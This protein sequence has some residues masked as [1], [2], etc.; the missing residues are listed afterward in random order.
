MCV[1]CCAAETDTAKGKGIIIIRHAT[2][3]DAL[4]VRLRN[5]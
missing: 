5:A 4:R 3:R 1:F 2:L